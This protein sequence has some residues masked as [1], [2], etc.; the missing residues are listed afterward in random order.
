MVITAPGLGEDWLRAGCEMTASNRLGSVR[1][2]LLV[3]WRHR[4]GF[5]HFL[6]LMTV[7]S[8]LS[9]GTQDLYPD[10]LRS[11]RCSSMTGS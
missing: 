7:M 2:I 11:V 8:C 6:L 5:A 4:G 10:S 3:L 9:H 1:S